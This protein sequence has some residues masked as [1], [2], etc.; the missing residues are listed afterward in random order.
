[1]QGTACYSEQ[2]LLQARLKLITP[3][4]NKMSTWSKE[5]I[6]ADGN[7][8]CLQASNPFNSYLDGG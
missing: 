1:M 8:I 3:W 7:I 6:Y 5:S 2:E 4:H